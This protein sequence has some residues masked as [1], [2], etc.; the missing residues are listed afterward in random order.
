MSLS[1]GPTN[2]L[3]YTPVPRNIDICIY[4]YIRRPWTILAGPLF[5]H[6]YFLLYF[7]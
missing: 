4:Y 7:N 6:F 3:S 1:D 5:N 2:I